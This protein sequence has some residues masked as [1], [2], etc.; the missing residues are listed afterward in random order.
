MFLIIERI[1]THLVAVIIDATPA[2]KFA[3]QVL[4]DCS[5]M[6]NRIFDALI[7]F[8]NVHLMQGTHNKLA[9]VACNSTS[10]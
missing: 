7:G 4:Q 1:E 10:T 8:G 6:L 9:V 5:S 2:K 3:S